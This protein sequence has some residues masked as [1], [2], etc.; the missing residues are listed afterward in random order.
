M[1]F[2]SVNCAHKHIVPL[3]ES[4]SG[5]HLFEEMHP[6]QTVAPTGWFTMLPQLISIYIYRENLFI[7]TIFVD[8]LHCLGNA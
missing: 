4:G 5:M 6:I 7:F 8:D 3:A 2:Y 1:Y